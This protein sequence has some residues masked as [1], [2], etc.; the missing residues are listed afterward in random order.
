[1]AILDLNKLPEE[2]R[3]EEDVVA[4]VQVGGADHFDVHPAENDEEE[5]IRQGDNA[6]PP[7]VANDPHEEDPENLHAGNDNTALQAE[8]D[9]LDD[10]IQDFGVYTDDVDIIFDEEELSD[11]DDDEDQQTQQEEATNMV[12]ILTERERQDI[13]EDLLRLSNN[14]KLKRDNTT[15]IA[16]K[17][18]VHV[19]TIQRVW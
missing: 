18:N 16:A 6:G 19:R 9:T 3:E 11:S 12:R 4:V 17:Y 10:L 13:Y 7:F 1:M 14:G 15:L 5:Q 2:R 8:H